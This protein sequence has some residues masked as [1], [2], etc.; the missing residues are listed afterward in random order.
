MM[1]K[2]YNFITICM[3]SFALFFS[4]CGGTA[5]SLEEALMEVDKVEITTTDLETEMAE[6]PTEI[7]VVYV[8]GEV[9][10]PGVYEL[11]KGSRIVAAIEAAGGFAEN[12]AREAINLAEALKDG[13]QINVPGK[14]EAAQVNALMERQKQGLVN[15]NQASVQDL[16][17]LPGI[18]EA[19]AL[20]IINYRSECGLFQSIEDIQNVS[21]IGES[22]YL[23][24]KDKIYID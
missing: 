8:C 9:I 3:L 12:A 1:K 5:I 15:I 10:L 4:G 16:C 6:T 7:I 21:G 14:E 22:L 20:S 24:I 23:Q 18:G 13:M 11:P 19:K 2:T 17:T